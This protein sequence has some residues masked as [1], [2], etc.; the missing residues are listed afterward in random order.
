MVRGI[1]RYNNQVIGDSEPLMRLRKANTEKLVKYQCESCLMI[2]SSSSISKH[3]LRCVG[4]Q[5]GRSKGCSKLVSKPFAKK[6]LAFLHPEFYS[7]VYDKMHLDNI[8]SELR[9]DPELTYIAN[10]KYQKLKMNRT[11]EKNPSA[12]ARRT[13]RVLGRLKLD[14]NKEVE[15]IFNRKLLLSEMLTVN[16][17]PTVLQVINKIIYFEKDG[18]IQLK[19]GIS[20]LLRVNIKLACDC[21]ISF[22]TLYRSDAPQQERE[23]ITSNL[24]KFLDEFDKIKSVTFGN[25]GV[26]NLEKEQQIELQKFFHPNRL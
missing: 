12:G 23:T 21:L 22:Y 18:N 1:A 7:D 4:K 10:F 6:D 20:V 11:L 3:K 19:R 2:F 16:M 5:L 15:K 13:I 26:I 8:K 25:I 17:W 9:S 24:K 14:V